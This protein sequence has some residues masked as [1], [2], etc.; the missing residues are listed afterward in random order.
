M[1]SGGGHAFA[2]TAPNAWVLDTSSGA[3]QGLNA[4]LYPKQ[5]SWED[6]PAVMYVSATSRVP[7]QPLANF[8]G[9]ELARLRAANPKVRAAA[10][11][12]IQ[13]HDGKRASVWHL[14]GDRWGNHEAIAYIEEQS[15]FV[16]IVLTA[17]RA[18]DYKAALP[19]FTALVKTYEATVD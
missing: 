5:G 15:V 6:S 1:I 4:V 14:E 7:E 13:T 16:T 10:L 9:A 17:R 12:A 3:T 11:P 19:A 8:V 18:G 2:V